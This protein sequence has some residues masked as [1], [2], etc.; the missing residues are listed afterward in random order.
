M[1]PS[2]P[3]EPL[4]I[5]DVL[6]SVG[7]LAAPLERSAVLERVGRVAAE[8][9]GAELGFIGLLEGDGKLQVTAVHGGSTGALE[10]IQVERGRGLG[11]KVLALGDPAAVHDYTNSNDITHEYDTEIAEEGLRG[12]LCLPL[13]VSDALLGVAYVSDRVPKVYSDAMISRVVNAVE[14]AQIALSMADRSR[15]ITEAAIE[16]ERQRTVDVLDASVRDHLS[17][18]LSIARTIADDPMSSAELVAQ[19]SS[20]ISTA[21]SASSLFEASAAELRGGKASEAA[22]VKPVVDFGLTPRELQVVQLAARGLSNPEIAK[23]LY[24]ARGTVKAYMESS[25][26]KLGAR[27]RVEAVMVAARAGLLDQI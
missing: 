16:V 2:E 15:E 12:M 14:S 9:I 6:Q 8:S 11:G 1:N 3:T 21:G 19:A 23:N 18:I 25:L 24:L 20:I 10:R 13:V 22:E 27:N 4:A 17:S 5:S 26:H 7:D